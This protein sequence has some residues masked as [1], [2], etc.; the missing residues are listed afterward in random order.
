M[1][2]EFNQFIITRNVELKQVIM[3]APG[4]NPYFMLANAMFDCGIADAV[5]FDSTSKAV[6]LLLNYL[7]VTSR[8]EWIRRTSN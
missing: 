7:T 4:A 8:R 5:L 2:N 1:I 6:G 3:A